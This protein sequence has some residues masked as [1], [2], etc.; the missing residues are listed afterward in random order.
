MDPLADLALKAQFV[1]TPREQKH[2]EERKFYTFQVRV[3]TWALF[4]MEEQGL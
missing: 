3:S 2:F 1:P 4:L